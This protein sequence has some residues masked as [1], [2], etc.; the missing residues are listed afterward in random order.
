MSRE[1]LSHQTLTKSKIDTILVPQG[2]EYQAVCRALTGQ[3]ANYPNVLPIPVGISPVTRYL[4][5]WRQSPDF[6]NKPPSTVLVM[7]L[8]GSLSPEYRVGEVVLYQGCYS[9]SLEN[10]ACDTELTQRL[11]DYLG[12]DVSL[13]KGLTSDRPIWSSQEK[14]HLGQMYQ[15]DVVDME[16]IAVLRAMQKDGIPVAMVRVVSDGC[17]QDLPDVSAAISDDGSLKPVPLA[18]AMLRHPCASVGLIKGSLKGL[19]VLGKIA[20]MYLEN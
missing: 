12:G 18:M 7:G 9:L 5:K 10:Y 17:Q 2:A 14:K 6:L 11:Q 3:K 13:V 4:E 1:I 20:L 8:C 15:T 16:G 19:K